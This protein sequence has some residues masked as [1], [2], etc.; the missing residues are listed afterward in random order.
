VS[1]IKGKRLQ[2]LI[3]AVWAAI[4]GGLTEVPK[5]GVIRSDGGNIYAARLATFGGIILDVQAQ[6]DK[7]TVEVLTR[8]HVLT[9]GRVPFTPD[10]LNEIAKTFQRA[11][12]LQGL[13][14]AE[15]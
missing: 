15:R 10:E 4:P 3:N 5:V 11:A 14:E 8:S 2:E 1:G 13:A 9:W 12:L 6:N 7:V